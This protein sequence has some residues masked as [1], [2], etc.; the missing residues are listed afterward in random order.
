[1]AM[2]GRYGDSELVHMNPEE[3]RGLQS[4][5]R[6][7]VNPDT[8]LPEAFSFK[9]LLPSIAAMA[10]TAAMPATGGM[11]AFLIPALAAGGT[12][13]IVNKGDMSKVA[14]DAVLAGAG[15]SLAHGLSGGAEL[16]KAGD[17]AA[18]G[19]QAAGGSMAA[20][21][22]LGPGG[23][24]G[25]AHTVDAARSAAEAG[26]KGST[27]LGKGLGSLGVENP[28]VLRD[29]GMLGM[30]S[31]V[32]LAAKGIG[33]ASTMMLGGMG[34][35][36]E[37]VE[38][39]SPV[40]KS[41]SSA[42]GTRAAEHISQLHGPEGASGQA[43][44]PEEVQ[45]SIEGKGDPLK[46]FAKTA[47]S[48]APPAGLYGASSGQTGPAVPP[49]GGSRLSGTQYAAQGG[50][51]RGDLVDVYLSRGGQ[52]QQLFNGLVP[53]N[54]SGDGMSDNVSFPVIGS[55]EVD[56]AMLSPDEYVIDAHTVSALGNGSTNT[57]A[58]ILDSFV[59][60]VRN[61]AYEKGQ[62]PKENAGLKELAKLHS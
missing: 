57:G 50:A 42:Y 3:V 4:M 19:A 40:G 54:G 6:L 31:P 38:P 58:S 20:T 28:G 14:F 33:G 56:Q 25:V 36:Q 53:D 12:S 7:T 5:G 11:S 39:L 60:N 27:M 17:A 49:L 61:R 37:P 52:P 23:A 47:T 9:S 45:A 18:K 48:A 41:A 51:V 62:Q 43:L 44:S 32:D 30:Q 29:M 59:N 34:Q 16:A 8:G 24:G 55:D 13:A 46:Y 22:G 21:G 15:G 26:V 10:A 2:K 1:M 35:G